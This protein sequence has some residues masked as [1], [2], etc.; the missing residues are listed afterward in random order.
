[1]P[2]ALVA[3]SYA[4]EGLP[5]VPRAPSSPRAVEPIP[6]HPPLQ[7]LGL[8]VAGMTLYGLCAGL[9]AGELAVVV[10]VLP[11]T[12][13]PLLGAMLLTTPALLVMH[14]VLGLQARPETMTIALARALLVAGHVAAGLSPI[15]LFFAA[16][17]GLW[18]FA[19]ALGGT[20]IGIA[21]AASA[22]RAL[23]EAERA[24]GRLPSPRFSLL[25]AAWLVLGALVSLR[26]AAD[27][28]KTIILT[29]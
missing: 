7:R 15:A 19:I 25:V 24:E 18:P 21:A 27:F 11:T 22:A 28:A 4:P 8:A 9:G 20:I 6:R 16:T 23:H 5:A 12:V 3:E 17:T 26:L 2:E 13:V 1:M 29:A 14:Q 10:R